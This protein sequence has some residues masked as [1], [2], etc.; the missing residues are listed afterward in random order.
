MS[1]TKCGA[2]KILYLIVIVEHVNA[3]SCSL[4]SIVNSIDS[5]EVFSHSATKALV[6]L[7]GWAVM[8]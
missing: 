1:Q 2:W 6:I 3:K 4:I 7:E 5:F 8:P